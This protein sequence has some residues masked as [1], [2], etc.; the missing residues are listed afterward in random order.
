MSQPYQHVRIP[1][2]LLLESP[3]L[4]SA[5]IATYVALASFANVEGEAWPSIKT[6][7]GRA[8]VGQA[9]VRKEI[10]RLQSFGLLVVQPRTT[11]VK[12]KPLSTSNLYSLPWHKKYLANSSKDIRV[13]DMNQGE[14]KGETT[15]TAKQN[16]GTTT[17]VNHN[18]MNH[19]AERRQADE[20]VA[21]VWSSKGST[22]SQ[23]DISSIIEISM[24][25][26]I[27]IEKLEAALIQLATEGTYISKFSLA[28]ALNPKAMKGQLRADMPFDRSQETGYL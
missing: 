9:T 7:A 19:R 21:R 4:K 8:K 25:N 14:G 6:L 28:Q 13:S 12:G 18:Q 10:K 22:Q 1:L 3:G 15:P 2:S 24:A 11:I 20:L 23:R 17:S 5:T 16:R 27:S 26:G